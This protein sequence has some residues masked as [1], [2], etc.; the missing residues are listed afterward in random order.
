MGDFNVK[1][2]ESQD[3]MQ[4]FVHSLLL[5][6]HALER[7]LNEGWFETGITR[8]GAEQELCI[9]GK[10]RK[11]AP[12]NLEAL[13][14]IDDPM[15]TTELAR[16]NLECN[17]SPREFTGR[18]LYD[19]HMELKTVLE[20]A[21]EK[22]RPMGIE[23][24]LYGILPSIRKS[25][26]D[27]SQ[28]TPIPRYHALMQKLKEMRGE[29]FELRLTG[30]DE[31][32]IRQ[33]TAMLEACNTSFQVHLQVSPEDFAR[34]YN[35]AQALCGPVM[36]VAVN[37]P[38]LFGRR[39][40]HETR[41]ALFQQS[42]DVRTFTEH[43]RDRSPRVTFGNTWVRNSITEIYQE[44]IARFQ[45]LLSSVI[46]EDPFEKMSKGETP[47]LRALNI[48][49]S[50][51]YRWNRPCY[52]IS[53]NGKPHLRIEN[54][55]FP[56]G[57]SLPDEVANAS[58][59]L[60]LM[61]GFEDEYK[62]VRKAFLFDDV[63]TNFFNAARF[64]LDT[65]FRWA[66]GKKI[67]P[68]QLILEQLLPIARHGLAK[69]GIA[70][71]DSDR[72]LDII[73]DRVESGRTGAQWALDSYATLKAEGAPRDECIATITAA[74]VS[75]QGD[76]VPVHK[77]NLASLDDL[78]YEPSTLLVEEFMNTDLITVRE[79]DTL[80]LVSNL[81]DWRRIRHVMVEDRKGKLVGLISARQCMRY[82]AKRSI[83]KDQSD[84]VAV[85]E[86]M[87]KKPVTVTPQ[88][89]ISKALELMQQHQVSCLP[90]VIREE[91]IG[92]I[93]ES[94]FLSITSN[95]IKRLARKHNAAMQEKDP[96][97]D[98]KKGKKKA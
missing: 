35:Y 49:N 91:L 16:F 8:I 59:W 74:I 12:L 57:P 80:D 5:D 24:V 42:M 21:I 4:R 84:V 29:Q 38:L 25:D 14:A 94:D 40:W 3:E 13:K 27:I 34:K 93:T 46:E 78:D 71:E 63:R 43:M 23:M 47:R 87:V 92:V 18:A 1:G 45:V 77:W 67:S 72:Y 73:H 37:S 79:D 68:Q 89:P 97:S 85:R 86:V 96:A 81:M 98:E 65:K 41:I 54:R 83:E 32:N 39:L 15:F 30:L 26:V 7:M 33:E 53:D 58:F 36:S 52:G 70:K 22:M 60:G 76:G 20:A 61:N 88:D 64:G 51:V 28:I 62:D 9:I 56:S 75:H 2:V 66:G 95:L 31:I 90:V 48:H 19:M 6:V 17:C 50:T 82:Y 10:N 69:A 44:D 11:P 55:I